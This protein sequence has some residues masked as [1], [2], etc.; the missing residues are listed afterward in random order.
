[1]ANFRVETV[2]HPTTGLV[3]LE[4]YYPTD[5]STLLVATDYTYRSHEAA[6][7]DVIAIFKKSFPGQPIT[8]RPGSISN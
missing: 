7:A 6:Q 2:S 4:I 1:M 5:P 8:T 3:A